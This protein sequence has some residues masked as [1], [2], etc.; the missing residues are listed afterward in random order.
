MWHQD[1][2]GLL[3]QVIYFLMSQQ[4][5]H[6]KCCPRSVPMP[7]EELLEDCRLTKS[8]DAYFWHTRY[9]LIF[10]VTRGALEDSIFRT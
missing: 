6:L 8:N 10:T 3:R 5:T 7:H 2:D 1:I 9:A 4:T